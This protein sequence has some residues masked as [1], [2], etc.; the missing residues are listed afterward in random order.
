VGANTNNLCVPYYEPGDRVTGR[1]F[2]APVVGKRFVSVA[3]KKD[4]G[5]TG[6]DPGATGGNVLIA[7]SAAADDTTIGVAEHDADI[8]K[9]TAVLMGDFI[10]PVTAGVAIVAG[11]LINSGAGGKA[12]VAADLA[13]AKGI[14][15]TDAAVDAD[16]VVKLF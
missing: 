1:A 12:A 11:N 9:T 14:A 13:H 2:G 10:V 7:P 5:S 4:P 6:L 15:L 8:G 16:C 3:G